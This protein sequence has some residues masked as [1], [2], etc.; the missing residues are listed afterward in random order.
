MQIHC[1]I[2]LLIQIKAAFHI[3]HK[4]SSQQLFHTNVNPYFAQERLVQNKIK[5]VPTQVILRMDFKL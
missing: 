4:I 2:I 3:Y 1:A 5:K